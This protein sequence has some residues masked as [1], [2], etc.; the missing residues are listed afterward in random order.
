MTKTKKI[1]RR[2]KEDI[3]AL[4]KYYG[5]L[6]GLN[7]VVSLQD[8]SKIVVRDYLNI[9]AYSGLVNYVQREFNAIIRLYSKKTKRDE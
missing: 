1:Q 5:E 8:L 4:E 6:E 7:I 3:C 2:Y 9:R